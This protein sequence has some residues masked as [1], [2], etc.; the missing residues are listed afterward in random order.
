MRKKYEMDLFDSQDEHLATVIIYGSSDEEIERK[1][2]SLSSALDTLNE[3][4][5]NEQVFS[6][7]C[8]CE[9]SEIPD[10][11][12]WAEDEEEDDECIEAEIEEE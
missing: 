2:S 1:L 10:I 12:D 5:E 8:D 9:D 11:D 7:C 6:E 4:I 3:G